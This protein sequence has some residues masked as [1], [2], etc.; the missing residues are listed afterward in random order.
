MKKIE[1][2]FSELLRASFKSDDTEEWLDVHFTRPVGLAFALMWARLG[3]HPNAVTI[4]SIVLGVTA[5]VMFY[6]TGLWYNVAGVVLL[7]FSNF[8][9]STDGQ[10]ARL[11]DQKTLV[12]RILDGLSSDVSFITIYLAIVLRLYPQTIPFTDVQ[13]GLWGLVIC[14]VAGLGCH[15]HQCSLSDYY[16]QI[17]LYFLLGREGSE[18]DDS[19]SQEAKLRELPRKGHLWERLFYANYATYCRTQESRTPAFQRFYK[20]VRERYPN[21]E[22]MPQELRDDFRRGSLPLMKYTNLLTFNL[23][24]IVLYIACLLNVPYVYPLVEMTVFVAMYVHMHRSHEAHCRA[25]YNKYFR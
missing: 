19:A 24:A 14:A 21:A 6:H 23:R 18:L 7:M 12:G 4:L 8:C 2:S 13:W 1:K 15:M 10:L 17:H 3:V 25:M 16:R 11:T 22:D 9:D 5:G 20:A